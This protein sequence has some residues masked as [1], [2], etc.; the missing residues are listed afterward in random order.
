M[1][2]TEGYPVN[3]N[4]KVKGYE[5]VTTMPAAQL[6]KITNDPRLSEDPKRRDGNP[7]L[8]E[9]YRI[10]QEVQRMF[11]GAKEKNVDSYARYIVDLEEG[12]QG[13]TPQIVLYTPRELQYD[14]SEAPTKLYL[15]WDVD[16]VA[17]DG[18]THLA[19]R[20][21][22]AGINSA[23]PKNMVDVKLFYNLPL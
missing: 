5:F 6:L 17:I 23:T 19:A 8:E 16:L 7:N 12:G 1:Q 4:V 14:N 10:R 22:A 20:F 9:L 15:P 11:Q 3:G 18:E 21:E 2:P 13:I